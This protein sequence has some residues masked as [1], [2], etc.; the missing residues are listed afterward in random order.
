MQPQESFMGSRA[1]GLSQQ[2][3]G[4]HTPTQPEQTATLPS[5]GDCK[6]Q[7]QGSF[8]PYQILA[9]LAHGGM[10][11]VYRVRDTRLDREV[12]LKVIRTG[13]LAAD[14]EV[15]RFRREARAVAQL[16]HPH[17]VPLF[18]VGEI[19]GHHYFTMELARSGSLAGQRERFQADRRAAVQL[20][21]KVARA[22][23][24]VHERGLLHRDL[25]PGNILL[26]DDGEPLISDF[27]LAK[28]VGID[29][30]L[31][32]TGAVVGTPAYMAPEQALGQAQ[33]LGPTTDVWSLGVIAYELICGTR[34]FAE[35]KERS[36]SEV[37]VHD[38]PPLPRSVRRDL[39]RD[40]ETILLKCLEK[41]PA[42]RYA[43]AGT[44]ADD[45]EA[46]L[47]GRP[48]KARPA[49]RLRRLG[50]WVRRHRLAAA[51]LCMFATGALAVFLLQGSGPTA[52][53]KSPET[54]YAE[55]VE[56]IEGELR[57]HRPVKLLGGGGQPAASRWLSP[58][59]ILPATDGAELRIATEGWAL[60]LLVPDPQVSTYVFEADL[61]LDSYPKGV[62][63]LFT[64][65]KSHAAENGPIHE[66]AAGTLV[67]FPV[68]APNEAR[69]LL[70][71]LHCFPRTP[72]V[73]GIQAGPARD[74]TRSPDGWY[75][76]RMEV[77]PD[78]LCFKVQDQEVYALSTPDRVSLAQAMLRQRNDLIGVA[79]PV[80][81]PRGGLGLYAERAVV[82]FRD[83]RIT[84][85]TP[86]PKG[87]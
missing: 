45:L 17:V 72:Q 18:D 14:N 84:P 70:S 75:H 76:F 61:R 16:K 28:A 2:A 82:S 59:K 19:D 85:A 34:P 83:V 81:P 40:L 10:G 68:Q 12:A 38:P 63:G 35:S 7:V 62:V 26:R 66:L 48:I 39:D 56:Q 30:D 20:L 36:L 60:L 43:S 77:S 57:Q 31:T 8:G 42:Q 15:D 49:S 25:K 69:T 58:G 80:F 53:V 86:G 9:Q 37:I 1:S 47:E 27:G 24:H 65:Q 41:D 22:V 4:V 29:P 32:R 51:A 78:L 6:P 55:A 3:T 73:R 11:V 52:A 23:Q 33:R 64:C 74:M 71:L 67:F 87:G 50:R 44:L 54:V 13:V 46:W 5:T 79:H 21:I